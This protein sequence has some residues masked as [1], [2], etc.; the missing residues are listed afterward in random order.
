MQKETFSSKVN[1]FKDWNGQIRVPT[2][3]SLVWSDEIANTVNFLHQNA[4]ENSSRRVGKN[5]STKQKSI[6]KNKISYFWI[7]HLFYADTQNFL[8]APRTSLLASTPILSLFSKGF[9]AAHL[10]ANSEIYK[11]LCNKLIKLRAQQLIHRPAQING[12][13]I[14]AVNWEPRSEL[15]QIRWY[16]KAYVTG[17]QW[18]RNARLGATKKD[19]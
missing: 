17:V 12:R 10:H 8:I 5:R 7:C 16:A 19:I 1:K 3:R 2:F 14:D 11:R 15:G 4:K 13:L 9:G 6:L 18:W